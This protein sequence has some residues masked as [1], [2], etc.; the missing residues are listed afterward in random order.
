[1]ARAGAAGATATAARPARAT[2]RGRGRGRETEPDEGAASPSV[3]GSRASDGVG[4]AAATTA[5]RRGARGATGR[6]AAEDWRRMGGRAGGQGWEGSRRV[7]GGGNAAPGDAVE[8]DVARRSTIGRERARGRRTRPRAAVRDADMVAARG[9][10]RTARVVARWARG[11]T[12]PGAPSA[13]SL[14]RSSGIKTGRSA[15]ADRSTRLG[16]AATVSRLKT[17]GLPHL[18]RSPRWRARIPRAGRR[19]SPTY[20]AR[21]PPPPLPHPV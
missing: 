7:A 14:I 8:R 4:A 10:S 2:R 21:T 5:A 3:D 1:M 18:A 20:A 15:R 16:A 11:W 17:A 12:A 6:A 19:P 9:S 13:T